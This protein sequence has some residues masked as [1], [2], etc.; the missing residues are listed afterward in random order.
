MASLVVTARARAYIV[1]RVARNA[2]DDNPW[3]TSTAPT[4]KGN[5]DGGVKSTPTSER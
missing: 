3:S 5:G 4:R 1:A 2:R